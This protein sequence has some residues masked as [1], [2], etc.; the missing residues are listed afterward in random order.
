MNAQMPYLIKSVIVRVIL[1]FELFLNEMGF[2]IPPKCIQ[3][4]ASRFFGYNADR[5]QL[6]GLQHY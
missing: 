2:F 4:V 5:D 1:K 3:N 6:T